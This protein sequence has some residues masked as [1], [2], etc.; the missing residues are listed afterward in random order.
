MRLWPFDPHLN[1]KIGLGC[2]HWLD[3]QL[4]YFLMWLAI[5][6]SIRQGKR[7]DR[8]IADVR[9]YAARE[10]RSRGGER[11]SKNIRTSRIDSL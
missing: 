5:R 10:E 11:R 2:Y 3:D 4:E 6:R 7:I 1:N 9:A 8:F